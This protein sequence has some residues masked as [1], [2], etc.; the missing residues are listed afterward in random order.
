MQ[1]LQ[2]SAA[3]LRHDPGFILGADGDN[4]EAMADLAVKHNS[5]LGVKGGTLEELADLTEKIKELK[6]A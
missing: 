6:G 4:W 5:P 2:H 1:H 3:R